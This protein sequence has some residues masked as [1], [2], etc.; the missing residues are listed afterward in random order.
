MTLPRARTPGPSPVG[1]TPAG[2]TPAAR[3][4]VVE[5]SVAE[6]RAAEN[7]ADLEA[8]LAGWIRRRERSLLREMVTVVSRPGILSLAG[9]LPAAEAFPSAEYARAVSEVLAENPRALQYS[10][11]HER[12]K[13][14]IVELMAWR[15]VDC[16]TE[17]VVI[18]TGA[19]QGI[20]VSTRLLLGHGGRVAYEEFAY[21]GIH[22]ATALFEPQVLTLPSHLEHGMDVETLAGALDRGV[23]PSLLYVIPDG[24]NPLGVSLAPARRSRL[25]ALAREHGLPIVEDDPYGLLGLDGDGF[26]P[27]LRALDDEWVIY[28][29]SFSKILAPGLRLGWMI[30]PARLATRVSVVKEAGDLESSSL[31]QRAV[32]RLLDSGFLP[33]HVARLRAIY[34][35]RRDALLEALDRHLPSGARWTRPG[36]GMFVWV[37]LDSHIDQEIDTVAA[38]R[39]CVEEAGVA[40]IPGAAFTQDPTR[41]R[42]ALRLSFSTL[43]PDDIER[44]VATLARFLR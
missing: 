35:R 24:H 20:D 31:T 40:F 9:G 13:E 10:P 17:Q 15:G 18:T 1:P 39:R 7:P 3:E 29:G 8:C 28:L 36:G 23:R 33:D 32:S 44:A 6:N 26:A 16:A 43:E 30:V 4:Q 41:G 37:E 38:L 2:P 12:L 21:T 19:Q 5:K 22:Q 25:V 14:Q 34:R 42:G 27:P 11:A